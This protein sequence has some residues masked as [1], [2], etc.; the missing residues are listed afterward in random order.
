MKTFAQIALCFL[1]LGC[2]TTHTTVSFKFEANV[3][4][5]EHLEKPK[6]GVEYRVDLGPQVPTM[7]IGRQA[8]TVVI[9]EK[10]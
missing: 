7:P 6:F 3:P 10:K 2:R 1:V 5:I 9:S 4:H 8:Q